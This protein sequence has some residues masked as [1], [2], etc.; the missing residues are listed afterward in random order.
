MILKSLTLKNY[1]RFKNLKLDFT[2]NITAFIGKNG[3]G[4]TTIFEAILYAL[5]GTQMVRT[6]KEDIKS[7]FAKLKQKCEVCLTFELEGKQYRIERTIKGKNSISS[8]FVFTPQ[9][10]NKPVAERESGV[11]QFIQKLLGMNAATFKISVFSAQKE[12]DKFSSLKAEERKKEIRRLLNIDVIKNA[13]TLLRRDIR[14][15]QIRATSLKS[16]QANTKEIK[17]RLAQLKNSIKKQKTKVKQIDKLYRHAKATLKKQKNKIKLLEKTSWENSR[18]DKQKGIISSQIKD[19]KQNLARTIKLITNLD[20]KEIELRALLPIKEQ[21]QK[22]KLKS[23]DEKLTVKINKGQS[24][25]VKIEQEGRGLKNEL[26]KIQ[27]KLEKINK[28]GRSSPCPECTRPLDKHYDFLVDK[29]SREIKIIEEKISSKRGEYLKTKKGVELVEKQSLESNQRFEKRMAILENQYEKTIKLES[30]LKQLPQLKKQKKQLLKKR[31]LLTLQLGKIIKKLELL[32]FNQE[33]FESK[34]ESLDQLQEQYSKIG[35]QMERIKGDIKE[36]KANLK[37]YQNELK[38]QKVLKKKIKNLDKQ[39]RA[40]LSMEPLLQEFGRELLARIRPVL[41]KETGDLLKVV[42][43]G[44]YFNI[45]LN[46]NYEI[47]LYDKGKK[48]KIKRFSGGEEDLINLCFRLAISRV[49]AQK[50]SGHKIDFLILDE[51]FASQ[52]NERRQNILSA[53]QELSTQFRQLFLITHID[54]IKEQ[55]PIVYS[56]FEVNHKQSRVELIN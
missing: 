48:Y 23:K 28:M 35:R 21:Y 46:D 32:N 2:Q 24:A 38:E 31:K 19:L 12:L 10:G 34:K 5:F 20:K 40:L 50:S 56:V 3:S 33:R 16:R 6:A 53:L 8:A 47:Q 43:K 4:K 51:I 18:L 26:G 25:L 22:A 39:N 9:K 37:N 49:I 7:D 27:Q 54:D 14:E 52:D 29:F 55:M 11:N 44:R 41:E 15:N 30:Q 45:E 13:I 42:T 17:C 36:N 1:R